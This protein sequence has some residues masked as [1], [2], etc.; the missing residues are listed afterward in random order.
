M[1]TSAQI[2]LPNAPEL[3]RAVLGAVLIDPDALVLVM[4]FL[5]AEHFYNP[6]HRA[7]YGACEAL[8]SAGQPAELLTVVQQLRKMGELAAAGGPQYLAELTNKVASGA[9]VEVHARIVMNEW[10]TR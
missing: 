5:R 10:A 8:F 4:G 7:I 9:N 2:A 1:S 6:S 3:E